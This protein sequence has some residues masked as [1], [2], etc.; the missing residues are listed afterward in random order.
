MPNFQAKAFFW[1]AG[2]VVARWNLAGF[3][4]GPRNKKVA[5]SWLGAFQQAAKFTWKKVKRQSEILEY[6]ETTT[7]MRIRAK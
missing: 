4:C 7:R 6:G 2:M 5:G 1:S 3:G